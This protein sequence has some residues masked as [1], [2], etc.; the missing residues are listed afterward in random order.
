MLFE[1]LCIAL[2]PFGFASIDTT[3]L[4]S[5]EVNALREIGRKLGKNWDFK[6]D[7]CSGRANWVSATFNE[8]FEDNVRCASNG[9]ICNIVSINVEDNMLSGRIP[10]E[11]GNLSSIEILFLNSNNFTGDLPPSFANL[12]TMKELRIQASGLEGP[13]PPSITLMETLSDLRISDLT[14]PDTLCPPFSN[15]TYFKN[16]DFSFNKLN[17]SIP[18]SLSDLNDTKYIY[19][20]GNLLSGNVPPWMLDRAKNI[21]LSYNKLT[22]ESSRELRC[23]MRE[24]N[25][26]ASFSADNTSN[27]VSCLRDNVCATNSSSLYINCGGKRFE[28]GKK[29]YEADVERGGASHFSSTGSRWGFSNSGHFLGNGRDDYILPNPS[30]VLMNN[31]GLYDNARTSAL[32]LTYYGFCMRNGSY[33]VSLH[34]AEIIL[35]DD[36]T[37]SSLGRRVFDIYIQGKLVEKDFDISEKAGGVR[38]A[39]VSTHLVN[40]TSTLEIRLHWAGKGTTSIP[41]EGVYGPL[42]SAISVDPNYPV[43]Q[44]DGPGNGHGVSGG[45]VA[46]IV[47]GA[48]CCII[49]I[50]GVLWWWGYL[51]RRDTID[52]ELANVNGSFTL[53]QIKAATNNFDVANKIGEGGFGSVYKAKFLKNGG[54]L[55]ELVDPRLGSDYDIQETMVVINLALLCTTTCPTDRPAMSA[56]VSMLEGRTV[57]RELVG[58]QSVSTTE[59]DREFFLKQLESMDENRIEEMSI[60]HSDS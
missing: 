47:V 48:V 1:I 3:C 15:R 32:S 20:T 60:A 7:S 24:T 23:Q 25:L 53:R 58:E 6:E 10:E 40:V 8:T 27:Q 59:I 29:V 44:E 30:R 5:D 57:S 14:G 33:N 34:F 52:L 13:I 46:G 12:I 45:I 31:S 50:L 39:Y 2:L 17:G 19:L 42:I 18:E 16:L 36:R 49:L 43:P 4:P 9:S 37:Y 21:D 22:F 26:F 28:D 41:V 35:T 54:N 55:M 51:R 11:L 56:V 38:K